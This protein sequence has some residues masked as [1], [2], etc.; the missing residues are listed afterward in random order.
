MNRAV[1]PYKGKCERNG[2]ILGVKILVPY[3]PF[4]LFWH[5]GQG[6]QE[7][8]PPS[9]AYPEQG[10]SGRRD[11]A[12]EESAAGAISKNRPSDAARATNV[13]AP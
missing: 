8:L 11:S 10:E 6:P 12:G 9:E 13:V 7:P 4:T 1:V 5:N 2:R 3:W